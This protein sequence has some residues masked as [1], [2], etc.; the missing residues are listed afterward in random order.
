MLDV[1]TK[2]V[3]AG[4]CLFTLAWVILAQRRTIRRLSDAYLRL[5]HFQRVLVALAVI[6]C[7]VYAQK[8]ST[9]DVE[10]VTGTNQVEIVEGGTNAVDIVTGG[11]TN[12]AGEVASSPLL[13]MGARP[14][15][16]GET[17]HPPT[18]HCYRLES[19]S[20]NEG[21]SYVMPT[22]ASV[23][24]TWHIRGAYEDVM[25]VG[26]GD[27]RF[28]LGSDLC[29]SLWIHTWGK[30]RPQLRNAANELAAPG[31]PMSAVPGESRFW[32]VATTN[33]TYLLTWENF[34]LGRDTNMPVNAQVELFGSGDFVTR[35][36][37]IEA[38]Y[39]RVIP[40]NPI[41]PANPPDPVFP[42]RSLHPYGAVQDLSVI[43]ET[44]A[45]CWVD[46]V[47]DRADAW[48]NFKGDGISN[49]SDPSFAAK[50]G[51]TNHVIILIGKTYEVTCDMPFRV[52]AKSDTAIEEWWQDDHTL[53]LNWPVDIWAQGDGDMPLLLLGAGNG[54]HESN[55]FT[56]H[57]WPSSLGGVFNW[58]NC[59]CSISG[60][61]NHFSYNCNGDCACGGCCATGYYGYEGY[62]LPAWGGSC[63]CSYEDEPDD[64][65]DPDPDDPLPAVGVTVSF[66][67]DVI[68]LE[69]AYENAEDDI[70]PWQSDAVSLCCAAYGGENGGRVRIVIS[71]D[72]NL[73]QLGGQVL[74]FER[75]L[76]PYETV[77]FTNVYKAVSESV[78][79]DDI[80]AVATFVE[81]GTD[82]SETSV[83]RATAIRVEFDTV[84]TAPLNGSHERHKLGVYEVLNF[85]QYPSSPSVEWID[86]GGGEILNAHQYCCPLHSATRPL[87]AR[88]R[89]AEY[90]PE[91]TVVEPA[92][93]LPMDVR[94]TKYGV[95]TNFAGGIGMKMDLYVLPRDVSFEGLAV[96][97]VPCDAGTASGYFG[98]EHFTNLLSHTSDNGAGNWIVLNGRH[99]FGEDEPRIETDLP[100]VTPAGIL[101]NDLQFGW[102]YGTLDWAIP[103]GWN[104]GDTSEG[105]EVRGR[106]AED[107]V[108]Q[109]VI[110]ATG[111]TGVRKLN[112]MVTREIDGTIYLDG[113][114]KE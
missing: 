97:E 93:I 88:C 60:G 91:I 110:F 15:T 99:L 40:P 104:E 74:T 59:C 73:I 44:N 28:P 36:N 45:Y 67:K 35:F 106:F 1:F 34:F 96:E 26:L 50:A 7:T 65:H 84:N 17:P 89:G 51:E 9:N 92:G 42:S 48:V 90:V 8:P 76:E 101:T 95:P 85:Y 69:D 54:S 29:S 111:K 25:R 57:V 82:W 68:F 87:K 108:H 79:E 14:F 100:R 94:Y 21:Y 6:V 63:G 78:H 20:T 32:T 10:G 103:Y 114:R 33:G 18:A 3:F 61:G 2:V 53:W 46:V 86:Q 19:V 64:P 113:V 102:S 56:M 23:R 105:A 77:G 98:H 11:D 13:I 109:N 41:T 107:T 22:D 31:M 38:T 72:S 112:H 12:A 80:E 75:N 49:L 55:G 27:F 4:A 5:T 39:R 16:S 52:I 66:T 43:E 47:V 58:T 71:G 24:G 37:G 83:A 81:N 62:R 70:V 30:V